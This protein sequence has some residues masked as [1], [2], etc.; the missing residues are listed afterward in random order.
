MDVIGERACPLLV[1][2]Q[3]A[4]GH[5]GCRQRQ[6]ARRRGGQVVLEPVLAWRVDAHRLLDQI[7]R[8]RKIAGDGVLAVDE[9]RWRRGLAAQEGGRLHHPPDQFGAR[10]ERHQRRLI[11][12]RMA[13]RHGLGE[14][15]GEAGEQA[16]PGEYLAAGG[17]FRRLPVEGQPAVVGGDEGRLVVVGA[18]RRR[19]GGAVHAVEAHEGGHRQTQRRFLGRT[20]GYRVP[21]CRRLARRHPHV[22]R[23]RGD[24]QRLPEVGGLTE[25]FEEAPVQAGGGVGAVEFEARPVDPDH[26]LPERLPVT[27]NGED[28]QDRPQ[29]TRQRR[30][31]VP[32]PSA[33]CLRRRS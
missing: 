8:R 10:P 4:G 30:R 25:Q 23:G 13:Q 11:V 29:L 7:A 9:R 6:S 26:A 12:D 31:G 32:S 24:G 33:R 5:V 17:G 21:A 3:N 16:H 22:H 27:V 19:H 1:E 2:R 14:E 18:H 20:G 15:V 28:V